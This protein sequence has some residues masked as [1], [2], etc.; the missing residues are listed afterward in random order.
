M[1]GCGQ[2][3]KYAA[4]GLNARSESIRCCAVTG[5]LG[6]FHVVNERVFFGGLASVDKEYC[7]FVWISVQEHFTNSCRTKLSFA[8]IG[9]ETITHYAR[10][11]KYFLSVLIF[12]ED[13]TEIRHKKCP[14][15]AVDEL[16]VL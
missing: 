5:E 2:A 3:R 13:V 4:A 7:R 14:R 16:R 9:S 1:E 10:G 11:V 15:N 8:K 12:W 6:G